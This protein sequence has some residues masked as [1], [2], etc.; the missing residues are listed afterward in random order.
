VYVKTT[1]DRI[2]LVIIDAKL[3]Q[4]NLT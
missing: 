4:I 2:D 1:G 3:C